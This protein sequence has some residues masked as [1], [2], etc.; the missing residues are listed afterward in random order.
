MISHLARFALTAMALVGFAGSAHAMEL[1]LDDCDD[2]GC[3]GS[4]LYL[5][6]VEDAG[7]T[8]LVTYRIDTTNY[9]GDR[10]GINQIGF[11]AISGWTSGTVLSAPIGSIT[12]SWAEVFDDPNTA[13]PEHSDTPLCEG[14]KGDTDKVCIRGFVYAMEDEFGNDT[15]GVYEWTFRIDDGTLITNTDEWHIGGQYA[16]GGGRQP[17]MIISAEGG[18]TTAVPE[19]TAALLFGLGAVLVTRR[20]RHR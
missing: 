7:G 5:S 9:T 14:S 19:P 11:K 12:G 17:G 4:T 20:A 16:T 18:G 6:V 13:G 1:L 2:M 8:F 10:L 3:E 15:R